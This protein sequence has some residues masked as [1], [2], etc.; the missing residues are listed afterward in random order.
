MEARARTWRGG[1]QRSAFGED[2]PADLAKPRPGRAVDEAAAGQG[3]D[4][5][6]GDG[7]DVVVDG[8]ISAGDDSIEVMARF[9]QE[10][11]RPGRI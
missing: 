9:E 11:S 2:R 7:G 3:V 1:G 6:R 10:R 4:E 8:R 5:V